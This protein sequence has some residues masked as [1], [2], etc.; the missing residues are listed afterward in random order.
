MLAQTHPNLDKK[1]F[2]SDGLI[3]LKAAERPFPLNSEARDRNRRLLAAAY[4]GW[5]RVPN[6]KCFLAL[7]CRWAC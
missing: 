3:R 7:W 5:L 1:L 6:C 4:W 2:T